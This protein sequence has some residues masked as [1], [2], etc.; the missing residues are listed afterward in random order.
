MVA[1]QQQHN[2]KN[3]RTSRL[4]CS[5]AKR[6]FIG[7]LI[8]ASALL[9]VS[10]VLAVRLE[11][12]NDSQSN[13]FIQQRVIE[14][15]KSPEFIRSSALHTKE[16]QKQPSRL[17]QSN[18]GDDML[19]KWIVEQRGINNNGGNTA[20]DNGQSSSTSSLSNLLSTPLKFTPGSLPLT[21]LFTLQH[22]HVNAE[23]YKNHLKGGP[24]QLSYSKK[25]N[26]SYIL[27][28][29]SGSSTGRYMMKTEFDAVEP[30]GHKATKEAMK[31]DN[32]IAFVREPLSRFYS[33]YD[34]AYVRTA[35]WHN[36][37]N[38]YYIDP[39]NPQQQLNAHPFPFLYENFQSYHDYED[40][41]CPPSTRKNPTNRR[42]CL[43][44]PT[45]ED[46]TLAKRL[47]RFVKEYDGR[48]PY[49]VHLILQVPKLL[50]KTS[51]GTSLKITEL[52]NTTNAEH[53][54]QFIA[55]K[56][57]G[58]HAQFTK[59]T[60]DAKKSGGV[61]EGRSFPRRFDKSLV[62]K[63]TERRICLLALLDYCCLN[64][65]LPSSCVG[66]EQEGLSCTMDYDDE[67]GQVR[68]QPAVFP[69]VA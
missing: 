42:E 19:A 23:I 40:I 13:R 49:E 22:C 3:G 8:L 9:W 26:L 27:I 24:G 61:I 12:Q 69:D 56:H 6:L 39:N 28:P 10:I 35:P 2:N 50:S 58:Q 38:P 51:D 55:K 65:P 63:E 20:A 66:G 1:I 25:Y 17:E 15:E 46:G 44:R 11:G 31:A 60:E 57:I 47:D 4:N 34:E 36:S 5:T 48:T 33:Q 59:T 7:V 30:R 64:F 29:K 21:Q 18:A 67:R 43:Y 14:L 45:R 41:F 52:Y 54:W 68:V 53:D 62:K 16:E 37:Q 32:I